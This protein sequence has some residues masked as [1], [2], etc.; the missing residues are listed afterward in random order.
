MKIGIDFGTT[1]SKSAAFF[2]GYP[3]LLLP[4]KMTGGIPSVFYYDLEE[5]VQI[6][7]YAADCSETRPSNGVF[8][9]K[10]NINPTQDPIMIAGEKFTKQQIMGYIFREI[11]MVAKREGD[12]LFFSSQSIDGAVI[13]VPALFTLPEIEFIREAA[14]IPESESG[15]GL[16]VLSLIREPV[17]AAISYF[18]APGAED[19]R[20]ILVY[21]L[22]G[23]TC[24]VAVVRA[25][26][27]SPEWYTVLGAGM[28]R[29][30][31]RDW[32]AVLSKTIKRKLHEKYGMVTFDEEAEKAIRKAAINTKE[33]LSTKSSVG[34]SV[35]IKGRAY[36]FRISVEEFEQAT[37]HLLQ[38]TMQTVQ[39]VIQGCR[40]KIDY[41]VCSGGGSNMP[42]VKREL[43]QIFP[44]I[45]VKVYEP[46]HAVA[47]GAAIYA[48]YYNNDFFLKDICKFSYGPNLVGSYSTYLDYNRDRIF[49][50]IFK[51][52]SLPAS[53]KVRSV[54]I[55]DA[56][57]YVIPIYESECTDEVYKP[58]QGTHIGDVVISNIPDVRIGDEISLT[59]T[60]DRSGLMQLEAIHEK[61]GRVGKAEIRLKDF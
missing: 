21:D 28:E 30:G 24:D 31:G 54:A 13:T 35:I 56:D 61:S 48:E 23:G 39:A 22:G 14:E 45:P 57:H 50:V 16:K 4:I 26:R 42:Q 17:A 43:E 37:S 3:H 53:G 6:G 32:D 11:S 51:G 52:A 5:G 49:N 20:T 15:A 19:N 34:G 40:Q 8:D 59:I 44:S 25:D 12:R 55:D 10:M 46:S 58:E 36:D 29:I 9:I 47:F 60:I 33:Y 27:S 2:G 1:Y 38:K 41:I 7:R 18:N